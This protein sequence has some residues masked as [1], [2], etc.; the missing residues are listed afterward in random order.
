MRPSFERETEESFDS[1]VDFRYLL[2]RVCSSGLVKARQSPL[3]PILN[4][5][6]G[7]LFHH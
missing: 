6:E 3:H 5:P 1:V 2:D 7:Q 4:C